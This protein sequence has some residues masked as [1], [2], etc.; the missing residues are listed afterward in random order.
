M[1]LR[2]SATEL[3]SFRLYRQMKWLS[4]D[5]FMRRLRGERDESLVMRAG[6]ALHAFLE[7]ADEWQGDEVVQDDFVFILEL[8]GVLPLPKIREI[9]VERQYE[10]AGVDVTLVAK[11]DAVNGLAVDD[12][13]LTEQFNAEWYQDSLQWRTYLS[14]FGAN[15]FTYNCFEGKEVKLSERL[16]KRQGWAGKHVW[17]ITAL[18]RLTVNRYDGMEREVLHWL[19]DL[20]EFIRQHVPER[21]DDPAA[22]EKQ[23]PF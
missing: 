7:R 23:L 14:I 1:L 9:K 15:N 18:H 12:H 11:A 5:E 10:I 8:D 2:T 4:H 20:V 21:I 3:E 13:K 17:E 22:I 19:R 6:T 16:K